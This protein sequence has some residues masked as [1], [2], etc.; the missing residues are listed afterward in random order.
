MSRPSTVDVHAVPVDVIAHEA[1]DQ[2]VCLPELELVRGRG[3]SIGVIAHH[4]RL[5]PV[6]AP[7]EGN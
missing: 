1:S 5:L 7:R 3:N 6:P 2:C 4:H